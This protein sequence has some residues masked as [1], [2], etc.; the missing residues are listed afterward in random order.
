MGWGLSALPRATVSSPRADTVP[1][2]LHHPGRERVVGSEGRGA[3]LTLQG[4]PGKGEAES[5]QRPPAHG[6]QGLGPGRPGQGGGQQ[7][8]VQVGSRV[9]SGGSS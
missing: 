3:K 4:P 5:T 7:A 9:S 2:S 8:A 1:D 6:S